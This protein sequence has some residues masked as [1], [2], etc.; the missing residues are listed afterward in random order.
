MNPAFS[1]V[2]FTTLAGA[3]QGL[4]M[5]LVLAQVAGVAT[6][7]GF[8]LAA[9]A[10]AEVMLVA[11]LGSSF[12]HLGHKLRAWRAIMMWRTSW[13]SREVIVMPAFMAAVVAWWLAQYASPGSA[14]VAVAAVA[15]TVL[16]ALLWLCTA[17]I[18]ACLRFVQEWAH[19]LTVVNYV[20]IGLSSGFVVAGALGVVA[21][22]RGFTD[23]IAPWSLVATVAA[24]VFRGLSL[25][26]NARLRPTSTLQ[27][28]T[29]LAAP[30]VAQ[31]AM[32]MTAGSY[33]TREFFHRASM[34]AFRRVRLGFLVLGF[35]VP[36]L[37]LAWVAGIG[38]AGLFLVIVPL[39]FAGLLAERWF[40]FAQAR[41]PQNLYYGV[42]S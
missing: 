30:R 28:A 33:N 5:A 8:A 42:V 29:G 11:A 31:T 35:A 2:A 23:W 4:V 1:I 41:H 16:C 6:R 27:S 20:L 40:F 36:S 26:R 34:A 10:S 14:W 13:M 12:L 22:E 21:G 7:E 37:L 3:A 25:R 32:G 19:P 39:Q 9:L 18:Y 38:N 17:M 15:A 24:W